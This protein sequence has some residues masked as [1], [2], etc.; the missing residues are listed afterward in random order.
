[1]QKIINAVSP[2]GP[3]FCPIV[4]CLVQNFCYKLALNFRPSYLQ[5]FYYLYMCLFR[6]WVL[7]P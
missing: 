3:T 2:V 5:I 4:P 7:N 1:M 6:Q